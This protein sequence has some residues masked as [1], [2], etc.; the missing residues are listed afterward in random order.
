MEQTMNPL[1]AASF[2]GCKSQYLCRP[3]DHW[4]DNKGHS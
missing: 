1:F 2:I 4:L 3:Y